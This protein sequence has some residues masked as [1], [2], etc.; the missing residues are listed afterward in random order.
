MIK[1]FEAIID[2]NR[3]KF[4]DTC[5][6]DFEL[7]GAKAYI[8]VLEGLMEAH[9]VGV[10]AS[11]RSDKGTKY[12]WSHIDKDLKNL[13]IKRIMSPDQFM[14]ALGAAYDEAEDKVIDY[15]NNQ[16]PEKE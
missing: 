12:W 16:E 1:I 2:K 11:L 8:P 3:Q 4:V 9:E 7:L 15:L 5:G 10:Q 6:E 14:S 13:T